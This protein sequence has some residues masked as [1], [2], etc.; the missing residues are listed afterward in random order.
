MVRLLIALALALA[1]S[2]CTKMH[3]GSSLAIVEEKP[4]QF[5]VKH[6]TIAGNGYPIEIYIDGKLVDKSVLADW[7]KVKM[8][9][10][11]WDYTRDFN[12]LGEIYT[13]R[14]R[15]G[16]SMTALGGGDDRYTLYRD[17]KI[18]GEVKVAVGW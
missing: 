14:K 1:L 9:I 3:E 12:Y 5:S 4:I 8:G 15:I 2:A 18:I 7:T 17:A 16:N 11:S 6:N 13:M 10:L